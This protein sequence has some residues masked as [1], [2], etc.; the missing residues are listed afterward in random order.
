MSVPPKQSAVFIGVHLASERVTAVAVSDQGE[1]IVASFAPY[2]HQPIEGAQKGRKEEMPEVWWEATRLALGHLTSQLRG[3]GVGPSQVR[4]ISVCGSPG[5]VVVL[6]RA[7]KTLMPAIMRDDARAIDQLPR[8]NMMGQDHCRR[9]GF[10]FRPTD[11]IAKIVWIKDTLPELYETAVFCHQPDYIL[12]RLKGAPDTSEY[13]IAVNTGCDLIDECWPDW[14]D[15]DMHLGVRERLPRLVSL[16]EP[17]GKVSPAAASA[18][19]LPQGTPVIMGTTE[20]TAG[21]LASGTRRLGDFFTVLD[22]TMSISGITKKILAYPHHLVRMFKLPDRAWSFSTACNTGADWIKNWFKGSSL[23]DIEA[24]AEKL[25]PTEYLAYPNTRK[26]ETFPFCMNSAEGFIFPASDDRVVQFAS[27][28]QG[29]AFFERMCY[30][31]IDKLADLQNSQGDVYTGGPWS[32]YDAWM[33][34]RADVTG[35]VN[36]RTTSVNGPAFGTAMIAAIGSHFQN[37]EAAA[38]AMVHIDQAFFPNPE[39]MSIYLE[40]YSHFKDIM[41]E[42]GYV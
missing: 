12:G 16:G 4:G 38:E 13:S 31:K 36:R 6:D 28:L 3:K 26:G 41:E 17:V 37:F 20:E 15:Y 40:H 5:T 25:L 35:R 1:E 29:T 39:R 34:C 19:G 33:Q 22:D 24:D 27:C 14:L 30:Q 10:Q 32:R 42:Q 23:D 9:M 21:F 2:N 7:G 11:A 8:L 18:T